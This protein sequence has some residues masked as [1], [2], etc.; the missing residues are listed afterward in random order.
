MDIDRIIRKIELSSRSC[1]GDFKDI[2][3]YLGGDCDITGRMLDAHEHDQTGL[4]HTIMV[5]VF[6]LIVKKLEDK[7]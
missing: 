4:T 3:Q 5:Y 7:E 2:I 6:A 1:E